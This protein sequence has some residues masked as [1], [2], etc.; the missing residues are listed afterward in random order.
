MLVAVLIVLLL[1]GGADPYTFTGGTERGSFTCHCIPDVQCDD[2]TGAC[3]GDVCGLSGTFAWGNIAC[4][5]GNVALLGGAADQTG[6]SSHVAGRCIDVAL[7][8]SYHN[9]R[10][11]I[12]DVVVVSYPGV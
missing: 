3:P 5:L 2:D 7:T 10:A 6:S 9:Y 8:M 11:V 12:Q 4:Q 1:T